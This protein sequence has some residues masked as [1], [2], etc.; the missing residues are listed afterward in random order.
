MRT[1]VMAALAACHPAV[2]GG[3]EQ[4][5]TGGATMR[6]IAWV[7]YEP[8]GAWKAGLPPQEQDLG[9]H[10]AYVG[11]LVAAGRVVGFGPDP[12]VGRGYYLLAPSLDAAHFA[13]DDPGLTSGV[14]RQVGVTSWSWVVDALPNT[15]DAGATYALVEYPP[16]PAWKPGGL[17][18][19][20]LA[21]HMDYVGARVAAGEV[22]AGGPLGPGGG[23]LV[24]V[25][26]PE[27]LT[28]MI[29]E[30]PAV[31]AGIFTPKVHRWAVQALASAR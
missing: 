30:D 11:E 21:A 24:R 13:A 28:A 4:P 15:V 19:Q 20:D 31:R 2:G 22:L 16:G 9:G 6:T 23:Y 3:V 10:F 12:E 18:D 7:T 8:G 14:L 27:R 25:A 17:T 29:E 5:T 26:G 1:M